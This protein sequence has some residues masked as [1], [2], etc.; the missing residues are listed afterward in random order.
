MLA[1]D[2]ALLAEQRRL[3]LIDAVQ[4]PLT[5]VVIPA[6]AS[7]AVPVALAEHLVLLLEERAPSRRGCKGAAALGSTETT[8]VNKR[9][10]SVRVRNAKKWKS[11][12]FFI[13]NAL[14]TKRRTRK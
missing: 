14:F 6:V 3:A 5:P 2:D 11:E 9:P 13:M 1:S 10:K 12:K 8:A 4:Y 7:D